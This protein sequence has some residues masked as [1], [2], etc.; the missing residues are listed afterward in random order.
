MNVQTVMNKMLNTG[1]NNVTTESMSH[2]M[3]APQTEQLDVNDFT[4]QARHL[5]N[6]AYNL[7][8]LQKSGKFCDVSFICSDGCVKGTL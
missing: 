6:M 7:L 3:T 4:D 8:D 1:E 5:V 2:M